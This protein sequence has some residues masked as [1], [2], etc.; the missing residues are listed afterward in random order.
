MQGLLYITVFICMSWN[1]S[2]DSFRCGRKVVKTGDTVNVLVKKCGK[3]QRKFSSKEIVNENGRQSKVAVSNWVYQ[4]TRKK[5]I[6]VSVRS[7]TIV[8]VNVE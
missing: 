8:Q 4:R 3:P 6:I 5:D 7:G 1:V 2:A